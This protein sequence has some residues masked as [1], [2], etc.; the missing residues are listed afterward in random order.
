MDQ[1]WC[2]YF[3]AFVFLLFTTQP[4][5]R[6]SHTRSPVSQV[7]SL[8]PLEPA[9]QRNENSISQMM[10]IPNLITVHRHRLS[11]VFTTLLRDRVGTSKSSKERLAVA[12]EGMVLGVSRSGVFGCCTSALILLSGQHSEGLG[13][14]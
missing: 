9:N 4:L 7:D 8:P 2:V 10:L 3:F 6:L 12:R 14:P 13:L 11:L 1:R 5:L